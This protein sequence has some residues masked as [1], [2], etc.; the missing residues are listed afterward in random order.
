MK[1]MQGVKVQKER[2]VNWNWLFK[3]AWRDARRNRSR[4]L[5]FISSIVLGIAALVAV[6][7]FRDNMQ[8]DI[9]NQ[10][11]ILA[12]ADLTIDSRKPIMP[13][14]AAVLDALG[15]ERASERSFA[16]MVYFHKGRGSRLVQ[17]RALEGD[18]PFYGSI[19]TT[20]LAAAETFKAGRRALVDKTVMLQFNA[21]VG[22]SVKVGAVTFLIAGILNKAPGQSGIS[23]TVAPVVY[24]PLNYLEQT[25]LTKIGSRI[26]YKYYF[27]YNNPGSV[28]ADL[29]KLQPLLDKQGL[30][31]ETVASKK[32][33]TGKSFRDVSKFLALSG[34]IALLLGCIG[35]GSAIH[36]YI[37]EKLNSIATL[38]C[39]GL[40]ARE[41]FLI[42]LIQIACLGLIGAVIG[43]ALGTV[44]QFILPLVLGDFI[45]VEL[46]LQIS[47]FSVLQGIL[48]GLVIS[49]LFALPSLLSVRN[50]SPLNAIR[51]SV[52]HTGTNR[53][54]LKWM[55]YLLIS[56]F[57]LLFTRLQM[58]TWL[59]ALLF[60]AS[61]GIAFLLLLGLSNLLM[62][63]LKKFMANSLS[64]LWRQGFANLYR[65]NNQTIILTVSIGL[66]TAFICTLFFVQGILMQRVKISSS[67]SQ[68]NMILF[69]IQNDQ[70]EPVAKLTQDHQLPVMSQVPI[71]T[72]RIDKVNG[73]TASNDTSGISQRAFRGEL[74]VTFQDT[75]TAAEKIVKGAWVGKAAPSGPVMV[76]LED[77]YARRINADVGDSIVFN[78]QGLLVPTIVGSLRSV[79][80]TSM[81]T[82]FRVIFPKGVLEDAPQFHVLMTRVPDPKSSAG[83]QAAVVQK[84]P[85][86]SVID[87]G[88]ILKVLD[89]L[90]SKIGFV[91]QFMAA[92]SM[93]TG[94]IVLISAVL[95]S[96]GQRLKESVLLRTLGAS[97]RQIL[98]ITALEYLFLGALSAGAGILLSLAGSWLLAVFTFETIFVPPLLEILLLFLS[99]TLLVVITGILSS[100]SV[101]NVPP[102]EVLRRDA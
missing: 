81:Q 24:I 65:P 96:R 61:I 44:T 40:K 101:L 87:L 75:L 78:V 29:K 72:V 35:V 9:D 15:S 88:L 66:S 91:I 10:A 26:Q 57:V 68:A 1:K 39:L 34:F 22:D 43:A 32:E 33:S 28:E 98:G 56:L 69:D 86:I 25:G 85:N 64:Y 13:K 62:R 42:Y 11:K 100:R 79:N 14:T 8:R 84:F 27:K 83:Y 6:Y 17:I 36:V 3:M 53:D 54:L 38:R 74:R 19:E 89:E 49:V 102:L 51:Q 16:S 80:W 70:K 20:P 12:G 67:Q 18:F 73:K 77:G 71:V 55:V 52:E 46:T 30:D 59:E 93:G 5:L 60:T 37:S 76:S 94:W 7:S 45:P 48:L 21:N 4:L 63:L 97:R 41:A 31:T 2:S 50:I 95:T 58:N 47:W 99:V 82:N 90:L 92:F 23:A